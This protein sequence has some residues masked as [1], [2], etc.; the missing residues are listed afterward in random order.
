M[1]NTSVSELIAKHLPN[2]VHPGDEKTKPFAIPLPMFAAAAALPPEMAEQF[3]A[4][5]DLPSPDIAKL[6]AEALVHLVESEGGVDLS[7]TRAEVDKLRSDATINVEKHRQPKVCCK[8][9]G[10]PLFRINVDTT[11]PVVNGTQFLEALAT[12]SPECP[13]TPREVA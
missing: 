12:L 4:E 2:L 13:H 6:T 1:P 8:V 3:A 11:N 5:A 10:S 7:L 9:C